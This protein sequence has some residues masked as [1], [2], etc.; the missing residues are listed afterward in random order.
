MEDSVDNANQD[1]INFT[2]LS[3]SFGSPSVLTSQGSDRTNQDSATTIKINTHE[4]IVIAVCDGHD[5]F[6]NFGSIASN[7]A[8]NIVTQY[9]NEFESDLLSNPEC[10]LLN[11]FNAINIAITDTIV[12][13]LKEIGRTCHKAENG[14]M[15]YNGSNGVLPGGTTVTICIIDS[16]GNIYTGYVG[17]SI[18]CLFANMPIFNSKHN[19]TINDMGLSYE[20]TSEKKLLS[21]MSDDTLPKILTQSPLLKNE[22]YLK[23][24]TIDHSPMS[25]SEFRRIYKEL[26][27]SPIFEYAVPAKLSKYAPR[28]VF[29]YDNVT[30][31]VVHIPHKNLCYLKNVMGEY[32]TYLHDRDNNFMIGITRSSGENAK[33]CGVSP[34]PT[35]CKFDMTKVVGDVTKS[36]VN[37]LVICLVVASDGMWDNW[38]YSDLQQFLTKPEYI[39]TIQTCS[40]DDLNQ[41]VC[42][43]LHTK[44]IELAQTNFGSSR[45][46][47]TIALTYAS[48]SFN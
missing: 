43:D 29:V 38:K 47:I 42:N 15:V 12:E 8:I 2:L 23:L 9:V 1:S 25:E 37:N 34:L 33:K 27:K 26:G 10:W 17:D 32:A 48:I 24:T 19:Q 13:A 4:T 20:I 21:T 7:T 41:T 14:D 16:A 11:C 40:L 35:I 46:D 36:N 31:T 3:N 45:D 28:P 39:E 5:K 6:C 30:D 22:T 44:T 18:P